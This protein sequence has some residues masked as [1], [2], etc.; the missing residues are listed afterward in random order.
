MPYGFQ[1]KKNRPWG[2]FFLT[3]IKPERDFGRSDWIR[4]SDLLVPNETR[5]QAALRSEDG[6]HFTEK[7]LLH[8]R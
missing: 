7:V 6:A 5:Y 3:L 2:R 1:S 8:K 4:T